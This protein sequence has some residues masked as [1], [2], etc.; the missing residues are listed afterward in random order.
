VGKGEDV[1]KGYVG[2]YNIHMESDDQRSK[3]AAEMLIRSDD[4]KINRFCNLT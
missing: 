4:K 3:H 1:E 2:W